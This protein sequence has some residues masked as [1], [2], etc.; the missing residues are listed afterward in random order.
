MVNSYTTRL[1]TIPIIITLLTKNGA[2]EQ[3]KKHVQHHMIKF[4]EQLGVN[5]LIVEVDR[6]GKITIQLYLL[7]FLIYKMAVLL[8]KQLYHHILVIRILTSLF[9]GLNPIL[10]KRSYLTVLVETQK[11]KDCFKPLD[12]VEETLPVVQSGLKKM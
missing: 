3:L 6:F 10:E 1:Y 12:I 4:G 8:L 5:I 2:T 9:I 7:F 11:I